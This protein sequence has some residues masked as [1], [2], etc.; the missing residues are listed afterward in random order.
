MVGRS[1]TAVAVLAL[2]GSGSAATPSD[3]VLLARHAPIVVLH[4]A[5]RFV[6]VPVDGFLA[7]SDVRQR[8]PDGSWAVVGGPLPVSGGGWRL[9]QRL[10]A[11]RDGLAVTECYAAAEAAHGASPTVYGAVL[12][13]GSRIA[14]QYWLFYPF[15][16]Y[17]PEVPPSP[18]F[19]Q[20]HEGD[21][22][23]VTVLLD[24]KGAPRTLGLSRHC[25]GARRDW[26]RAERRGSRPVVYVAL[27]SHAGYFAPGTFPLEQ[28]CWPKEAV[29]VFDTYE[30]PLRDFTGR[31]RTVR[32]RVVAVRAGSPA[33]M[34]FPGTWGEDQI[35]DFPEAR[36]TYKAGPAGPAFHEAWR[37]PFG[38][39][40]S[41]RKG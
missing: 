27:G 37:R 9:D 34:R 14:I 16:P 28:G 33:W 26:T 23:L 4:P 5:E 32:P 6:P 21:W 7:D 41:W 38:E 24:G 29:I 2:A 39:P 13:R 15:N 20:L 10:C 1:L 17:S 22:E 18:D 40:L 3:A 36:F 19:A 25:S 35:I 31:G 11:V 30:K 12:R 8:Q